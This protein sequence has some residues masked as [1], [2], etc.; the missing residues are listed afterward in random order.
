VA[1][2]Q[3]WGKN[4]DFPYTLIAR[5]CKL[6]CST[7]ANLV[8]VVF[9][10]LNPRISY[11]VALGCCLSHQHMETSVWLSAAAV[12]KQV[13]KLVL[14]CKLQL[15]A[16]SLVPRAIRQ[17]ATIMCCRSCLHQRKPGAVDDKLKVLESHLRLMKC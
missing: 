1:I 15:H 17:H 7:S 9:C 16:A 12:S 11:L 3:S 4:R 13:Y 8:P 6:S 10:R 5:L 2:A 14:F